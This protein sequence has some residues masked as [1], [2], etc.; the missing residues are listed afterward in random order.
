MIHEETLTAMHI[1]SAQELTPAQLLETLREQKRKIEPMMPLEETFAIYSQGRKLAEAAVK[2]YPS[3]PELLEETAFYNYNVGLSHI[4]QADLAREDFISKGND[5]AH[6]SK[7]FMSELIALYEEALPPLW[8]S[9]EIHKEADN[10]RQADY[11]L[12][13]LQNAADK[14]KGVVGILQGTVKKALDGI[15]QRTASHRVFKSDGMEP[16]IGKA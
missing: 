13:A 3:H 7:H 16:I 9:Y 8:R 15:E 5:K 2:A 12:K 11:D 14:M 10:A 6:A 1:N 4:K